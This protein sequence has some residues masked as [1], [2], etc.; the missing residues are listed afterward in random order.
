MKFGFVSLLGRPNAGK[1]TLLN[2][3]VGTKLA[4][5]SDKPQTTRTRILGVRNYPGAQAVFLD[6]PGI[7]RPLHRMN[8]RMVD[9][10]VDSIRQVD[11]LGLVVDAAERTGHGDRYVIDLVKKAAVPVILILN[12]VDLMKKTRLLPMIAEYAR[13]AE[14]AEI[15]PI[16]AATG[17]NVDRLERVLLERLP[18]GDALYPDDYLTDQPERVLAAEMVR[19]K[20][21]QFTHAEIPFSTAVIVD[22][23]EEPEKR[24]GGLLRLFC[25]IVVDRESQKPIVVG[26]GGEMIKRIGTAA[27]A[28]LE[29]MFGTRVYLDL[30]VSVRNDWR[31]DERV[32]GEIGLGAGDGRSGE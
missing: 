23:F 21:L 3:L 6:T 13:Q 14:F 29:A 30:R 32:L 11:V 17:E 2:R 18:E 31:E 8:V 7:H 27:R 15:V 26:R 10:A 4:I 5:V 16:S 19:E 24:E 1:S 25:T 22:R 28:D 20:L 12:K 9:A